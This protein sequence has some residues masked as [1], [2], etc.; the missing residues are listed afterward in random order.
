[1]SR[2]QKPR[3]KYDPTRWLDRSVKANEARMDTKP[4]T[5][6]RQRDLGIAFRVAFDLMIHGGDESA[7]HTLAQ[8]LNIALVM[9]ENDF[10]KEY[11]PEIKL[12]LEGLV[13]AKVRFD[14]TGRWGFDGDAIQVIRL[15]LELHEEQMRVADRADIRAATSL[16]IRAS[17]KTNSSS[18]RMS[19]QRPDGPTAAA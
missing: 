9:C 10:G 19:F 11:E 8:A 14:R 16:P 1:M 7:W 17:G 15:G 4:L 18:F 5:D 2:S 13:R 3:K 12:A 6:D